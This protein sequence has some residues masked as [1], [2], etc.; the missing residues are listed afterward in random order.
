MKA[1]DWTDPTPAS[2]R[3]EAAA[4]AAD[5]A[6]RVAREVRRP[7]ASLTSS[8]RPAPARSYTPDQEAELSRRGVE[9][10]AMGLLRDP[11]EQEA[12]RPGPAWDRAAI[13]AADEVG[14]PCACGTTPDRICLAHFA[15]QGHRRH[16]RPGYSDRPALHDAQRGKT[17]R[18]PYEDA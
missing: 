4:R 17:N 2:V 8:S 1:Q 7:G 6:R 9:M 3:A 15:L 16:I 11:A 12:H 13:R 5:D 18:R 10:A 14:E